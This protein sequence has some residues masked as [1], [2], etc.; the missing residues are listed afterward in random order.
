MKVSRFLK[1]LFSTG[2]SQI[3]VLLFGVLL[4]KVMA[5]ALSKEYLGLFFIIRRLVAVL[6]PMVTLNLSI[7]LARYAGTESG[8]SE[9]YLNIS[10]VTTAVLSSIIF[11]VLSLFHK[12]FAV[13]FFEDSRYSPFVFVLVLFLFA[14]MV[15]LVAYSYFRGKLN[16]TAANVLKVLFYGFPL[17]LA[18]V[19]MAVKTVDHSTAL[20]LYFLIYSL[21]GAI[22]SFYFLRGQFSLAGITGILKKKLTAALLESRD[23]FHFS[24]VRVPT[25]LFNALIFGFPVFMA[26]HKISLA[27][28]GYMGIVVA[29]LRLLEVFSMPFNMIFLPKFSSLKEKKEMENIKTYSRVVLDFILTFLP[30]MAITLFG[31]TRFIVLL[32]FGADYLTASDSVAIAILFSMFYL[33]FALVRGILDGLFTFPFN[34]IISLAGFVALVGLSYLMGTDIFNLSLAFGTGLAVLG[35]MSVWLLVKK[36]G[37]KIPWKQ[38]LTAIAVS[39]TLFLALNFSDGFLK[40]FQLKD[41]HS[42]AI[43]VLYRIPLVFLTWFFYWRKT[44]WYN[45]VMK[46]VTF[47]VK[48]EK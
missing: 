17:V 38:L 23:L 46:R 48:R 24:L 39:S 6:L 20:H 26:T 12:S 2:F 27:A 22:I 1:D 19:L 33:A 41:L 44:L 42:F 47:K 8:K 40:G 28:A 45:E 31:L 21:Y 30:V 25:V 37:L 29:V 35:V 36:L 34:N 16:M 11:I 7:G 4:L 9:S 43:C 13:L 3:G 5:A 32:W 10:L 15:F 14:N 18:L